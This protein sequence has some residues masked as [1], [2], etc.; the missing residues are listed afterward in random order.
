MGF[1][2]TKSGGGDFYAKFCLHYQPTAYHTY[3]QDA[4]DRH[5]QSR[6]R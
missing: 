1:G 3:G 2:A 4:I 6:P 5:G